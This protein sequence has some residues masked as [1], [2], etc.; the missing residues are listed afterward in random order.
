M[1]KSYFCSNSSWHC[2]SQTVRAGERKFWENGHSDYVSHFMRYMSCVTC[3]MSCVTCQVSCFFCFVYKVLELV[4][5]GSVIKG[6]YPFVKGHSHGFEGWQLWEPLEPSIFKYKFFFLTDKIFFCAF[7][8]ILIAH[9]YQV[10]WIIHNLG[11]L[12]SFSKLA[13]VRTP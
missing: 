4:G 12:K 6:A 9:L 11:A 13:V 10:I 2:L 3:H 5:G 8:K 1:I 7:L